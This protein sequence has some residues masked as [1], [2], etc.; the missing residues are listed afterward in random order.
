MP[1]GRP[2]KYKK[3]YCAKLIKHMAAGHSFESFAGVINV[4]RT[5]L[6]EWEKKQP[7]FSYA[8]QVGRAKDL[9]L[10]ENIAIKM[11]LGELPKS[12]KPGPL[13][14]MLKGRHGDIYESNDLEGTQPTINIINGTPLE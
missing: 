1:A 10:L 14:Y 11:A 9:I 13:V 6:Y 4:D 7:Q 8:K 5:T 12:A 3:E 2:T